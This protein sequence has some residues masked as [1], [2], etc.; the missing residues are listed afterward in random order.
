MPMHSITKERYTKLKEN[1]KQLK[2]EFDNIKNITI[3]DMW[4]NDLAELK[5]IK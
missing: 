1:L 2:T 5:K 4:L 3:E